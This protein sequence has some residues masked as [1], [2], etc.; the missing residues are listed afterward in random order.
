M[1]ISGIM[2][3][4]IFSKSNQPKLDLP[5]NEKEKF[6]AIAGWLMLTGMLVYTGVSFGSLPESI[7][8]HFGPSGTPDDFGGKW[9]IWIMPLIAFLLTAMLTLLTRYPHTFNYLITITPENA[10]YQ[11]RL[12]RML[13]YWLTIFINLLFSLI[14]HST[15]QVAFGQSEGLDMYTMIFA[16]LGNLVILIVYLIKSGQGK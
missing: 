7:P 12:A 10:E 13:L 14:Q 15:I 11:Y 9:S 3:K 2:L 8:T 4:N 16:M 5:I 6:T 1:Q